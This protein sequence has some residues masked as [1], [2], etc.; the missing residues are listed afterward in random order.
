MSNAKWKK[1]FSLLYGTMCISSQGIGFFTLLFGSLQKLFLPYS[2][3]KNA[4]ITS[5]ALTDDEN[6]KVVIVELDT[7]FGQTHH[8]ELDNYLDKESIKSTIEEG[9]SQPLGFFAIGEDQEKKGREEEMNCG[10]VSEFISRKHWELL[11]CG[12]HI[13]HYSDEDT[14]LQVGESGDKLYSICQGIIQL[15]DSNQVK[16]ATLKSGDFFGVT[17]FLQPYFY[18]SKVTYVCKGDVTVM[19]VSNNFIYSLFN[20]K[21]ISFFQYLCFVVGSRIHSK[22][23]KLPEEYQTKSETEDVKTVP[24]HH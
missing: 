3:I 21:P 22:I 12:I 16:L 10:V 18:H 15:E 9:R 8:F 4:R 13:E 11:Q 23:Q 20:E 7:S 1:R 19:S 14:I 6:E 17:T 24:L 5:P 2:V